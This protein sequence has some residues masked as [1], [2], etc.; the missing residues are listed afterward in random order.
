MIRVG[1]RAPRRACS[2]GALAGALLLT[3]GCGDQL[4]APAPGDTLVRFVNAAPGTANVTVR[5]AGEP[6]FTGVESGDVATPGAYRAL[7]AG[8]QTL[9]VQADGVGGDITA[10]FITTASGSRYTVAL[11]RPGSSYKIVVLGDTAAPPLGQKAKLRLVNLAPF[12]EGQLDLYVTAPGA[13]LA[14]ATPLA[15]HVYLGFAS[16]YRELD[17]GTYQVRVTRRGTTIVVYDAGAIELPAGAGRTVFALD[18]EGSGLPLRGLVLDD[19]LGALL[20]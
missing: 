1:R 16:R 11:L 14:A 8:T 7:P 18:P 19:Q 17:A 3:L 13:D 4:T 10:G 2:S 20:Q 12:A 5:W 15:T 6:A 9:A